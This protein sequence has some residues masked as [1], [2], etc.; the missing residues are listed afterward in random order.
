MNP[1]QPISILQFF[2]LR[3]IFQSFAVLGNINIEGKDLEQPPNRENKQ[4]YDNVDK[5]GFPLG[6]I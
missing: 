6:I 2:V 1:I 4:C 3:L 5:S